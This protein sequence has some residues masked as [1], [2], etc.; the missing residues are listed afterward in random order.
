MTIIL[1]DVQLIGILLMTVSV[2]ILIGYYSRK[3]N[4]S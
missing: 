1:S 2:G 3:E 4:R